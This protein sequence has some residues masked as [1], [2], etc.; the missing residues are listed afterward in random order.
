MAGTE[1]VD[2][3]G[4]AATLLMTLYM[5]RHDARSRRPILGDPYAEEVYDRIEHDVHGLWQL[6]GDATIIACRAA[7]LDGWTRAFLGAE[8]HGQVLHL[9][10]GLDSRPLRLAPPPSCRWLDVDQPEVM[11]VR[12]RLYDF[13]AHV[14]QVPGSVTAESWWREVDPDRATLVVAE[15]LFMYIRPA[16][17]HT[18]VD[19]I[20]SGTRRAELAFDAVSAWSATASRWA[21]TFRALGMSFHWAWHP[22]DFARRHR[23]LRELDDIAVIDEMT[24][25][26]PRVWLRPFLSAAGH[27]PVVQDALRIHRFTTR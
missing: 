20:V 7:V 17:V 14:R 3:R 1:K 21:P 10:C 4:A 11:D 18:L 27:L 12:R 25:R 9:G 23:T 13:P 26:D 24:V 19:R 16:A 6:A 22:A 15:G 2:L 8:S 5:R